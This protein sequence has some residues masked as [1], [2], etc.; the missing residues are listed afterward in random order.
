MKPSTKRQAGAASKS[1]AAPLAP[2]KKKSSRPAAS[3][4]R[5][6]PIKKGK[7]APE[8]DERETYHPDVAEDADLV[9]TP[10]FALDPDYKK[11]LV[12]TAN[13]RV[14]DFAERMAQRGISHGLL[15]RPAAAGWKEVFLEALRELPNVRNACVRAGVNR[16]TAY[17]HQKS[18]PVFAAAWEEALTEGVESLEAEAMRRAYHGTE[19]ID[20][21]ENG[22]IKKIKINYSDSLL[23]TLLKAHNPGKYRDTVEVTNKPFVPLDELLSRA[24]TVSQRNGTPP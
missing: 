8:R 23:T 10:A 16:T 20:L 12:G 2:P 18:D 19:D 11:K 15:G 5:G 21:H 24:D 7:P 14:Q 3:P 1:K 9:E 13:A 22:T 17:D 6:G 4:A